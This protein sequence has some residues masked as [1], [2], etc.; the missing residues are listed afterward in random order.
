MALTITMPFWV[1][2]YEETPYST[3]LF[4]RVELPFHRIQLDIARETISWL[5]LGILNQN[6]TFMRTVRC[7]KIAHLGS[8]WIGSGIIRFGLFRARVYIG[9][10]EVRVGS[11]SVQFI[12]GYGSH[13]VNKISGR[14]GFGSGHFGFGSTSDHYGFGSVRFWVGSILDFGSKSV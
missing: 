4:L 3:A 6:C 8:G 12:S 11:G 1:L 14:F 2:V 5:H 10:R 9:S 7:T 13:R